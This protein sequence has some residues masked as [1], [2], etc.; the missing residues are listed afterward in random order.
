MG[1]FVHHPDGY[2]LINGER[3][4]MD[5]FLLVEPGYSLPQKT[6]GRNYQQGVGHTLTD[7]KTSF[8]AEYP[9]IKG[10][11]Y[12]NR[13]SDFILMRLADEQDTLDAQET[14]EQVRFDELSSI[15]KR[16]LKFPQFPEMVEALWL[17][18]VEG[19]DL[20]TSG[21]QAIQDLRDAV[22]AQYPDA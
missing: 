16:K 19:E 22:R 2:I 6:I 9:W 17:H 18:I 10:D 1:T 11:I 15:E 12:I 13:L 3:F 21:C 5:V 14:V 7:G 8:S 20:N 4:E